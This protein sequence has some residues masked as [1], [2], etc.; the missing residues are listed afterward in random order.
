M[1]RCTPDELGAVVGA[2][3]AERGA[4]RVLRPTG[5]DVPL[6][7]GLDVV[8]DDGL[9]AADLDACDGV[10]TT[11]TRGHRRDRDDR[12]RRIT[13]AGPSRAIAR[14]RLP[15]VRSA[16]RPGRRR[17]CPRPSPPSIRRR[18][19]PGSAGR[20]RPAT[21]S[22]TGCRACTDRARSRSSWSA[23]ARVLT[24]AREVSNPQRLIRP[25]FRCRLA[26]SPGPP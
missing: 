26:G 9:S 8:A 13:G 7:D 12:A 1:R 10:V 14:A 23:P 25:V 22:L 17:W 4:H 24:P 6:P 20:R 5:L 15:P 11:A 2:A 3:L 16:R 18:P 19:S 21:S